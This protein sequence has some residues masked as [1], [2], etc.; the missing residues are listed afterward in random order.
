MT[1]I[2]TPHTQVARKM[3]KRK[4][5][6]GRTEKRGGN[7]K[8]GAGG[9]GLEFFPAPTPTCVAL[10]VTPVTKLSSKDISKRNLL[11]RLQQMELEGQVL[12][13]SVKINSIQSEK[14]S[15]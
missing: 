13:F 2:D 5:K 14:I 3:P 8:I 6:F 1:P 12:K 9:E 4:K 11:S 10:A 7:S 15:C